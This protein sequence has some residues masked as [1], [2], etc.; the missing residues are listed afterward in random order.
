MPSCLRK[1]GDFASTVEKPLWLANYKLVYIANQAEQVLTRDPVLKAFAELSEEQNAVHAL[2][3]SFFTDAKDRHDMLLALEIGH[4]MAIVECDETESKFADHG[5][6]TVW[7][8]EGVVVGGCGR[9]NVWSLDRVVVGP[10]G[11]WR[12]W[13]L[14]GVVVGGCGCWRVWSLEGV[15]VGGCGC[16]RVWS[17]DRVVVGPSGCWTVWP[18][19]HVVVGPCGRWTVWSLDGVMV[20]PHGPWTM[21]CILFLQQLGKFFQKWLWSE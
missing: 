9:W 4:T 7:S 3:C 16:W 1:D 11:C 12:V 18:L 10:C 13:S 2:Y 5:R 14:E 17:L 20:G 8:L 15:V 6:W 19:D 21:N